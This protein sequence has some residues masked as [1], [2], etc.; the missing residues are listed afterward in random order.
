[1]PLWTN[2]ATTE[3]LDWTR[4]KFEHYYN[5]NVLWWSTEEGACRRKDSRCW[6]RL[7]LA[8]FSGRQTGQSC[9]VQFFQ[10]EMI[11]L[12]EAQWATAETETEESLSQS[13]SVSNC[14]KTGSKKILWESR[15]AKQTHTH[16]PQVISLKPQQ[17]MPFFL[18]RVI[19]CSSQEVKTYYE[20]HKSQANRCFNYNYGER[21]FQTMTFHHR[22]DYPVGQ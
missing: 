1:M 13:A 15:S 5:A 11:C 21:G 20:W 7:S 8:F 18:W 12:D 9:L 19:F 3:L 16:L 6:L 2:M 14:F 17:R 22:R 4:F 10:C